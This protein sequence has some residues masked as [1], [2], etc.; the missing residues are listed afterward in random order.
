MKHTL[1]QQTLLLYLDGNLP[2]DEMQQIREHLST[3]SDCSRQ[4]DA[5]ASVWQSETRHERLSLSPF[6]WTKLQAQIEEYEQTPAFIGNIK[7]VLQGFRAR[8]VPALAVCVAIAVGVYLGTP[9]GSQWREKDQLVI[10]PAGIADELGLDQFD[11]MPPGTL[12]STLVEMSR[13]EQQVH[14]QRADKK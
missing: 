13:A 3:C 1:V 4:L 10:Q 12:G 5:L 11:V 9:R 8:S 7:R 6:L 14:Q 2:N